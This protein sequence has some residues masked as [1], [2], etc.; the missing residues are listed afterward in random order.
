MSD[1]SELVGPA[2]TV[3]NAVASQKLPARVALDR[4]EALMAQ[5]ELRPAAHGS[6]AAFLDPF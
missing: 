4:L 1:A 3:L 6:V 5:G 2:A